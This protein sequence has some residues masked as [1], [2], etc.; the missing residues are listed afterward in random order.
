MEVKETLAKEANFRVVGHMYRGSRELTSNRPIRSIDDLE[1]LKIRVTPIKERLETWKAFGASPT[2]M[3]A[4][5]P[6]TK[7]RTQ[8]T[9]RAE[10]SR[11]WAKPQATQLSIKIVCKGL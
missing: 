4:R 9:I 1:G 7:N 10:M 11:F 8:N 3:A 6:I 5:H 2:T